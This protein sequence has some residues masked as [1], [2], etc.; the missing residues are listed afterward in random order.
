MLGEIQLVHYRCTFPSS[1]IRKSVVLQRNVRRND[2]ANCI[3][4]CGLA[5]I[6]TIYRAYQVLLFRSETTI[7]VT[8][9]LYGISLIFP[10]R[11]SV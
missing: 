1:E 3:A 10:P 8:P 6:E 4:Q 11:N 2:E 5:E 9:T 7:Q